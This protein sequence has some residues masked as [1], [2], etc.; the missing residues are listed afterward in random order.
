MHLTKHDAQVQAL[1]DVMLQLPQ[2]ELRVT[3]HFWPGVY[4]REL[5]IP[6][7]VLVVGKR[8]TTKHYN[9]LSRGSCLVALRGTVTQLQAPCIFESEQGVK[10]VIYALTDAVW[11]TT[12]ATE[13]KNL[14]QLEMEL[15]TEKDQ[16]WLG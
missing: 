14:T 11:A 3:H 6:Q 5:A 13:T 15:T 8:H 10:K 4:V 12:H 9:I 16:I 2:A 7:G 1:Q